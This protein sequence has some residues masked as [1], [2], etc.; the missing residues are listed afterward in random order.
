MVARLGRCAAAVVV[1]LVSASAGAKADGMPPEYA[2]PGVTARSAPAV[3]VQP[4]PIPVPVVVAP[5]PVMPGT[6]A[7]SPPPL[8]V[9]FA[10]EVGYFAR[11]GYEAVARDATL[12]CA[13]YGRTAV[14]DSRFR[15]QSDWY[16]RFKCL[17][18]G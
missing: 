6:L 7:V 2:D 14:L 10:E 9:T 11:V 17:P 5:E 13:R 16:A 4:A 8:L 1:A 18:P 12:Y 3:V 15:V